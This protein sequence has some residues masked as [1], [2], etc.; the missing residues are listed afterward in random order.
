[1]TNLPHAIHDAKPFVL[2]LILLVGVPALVLMGVVACLGGGAIFSGPPTAAIDVTESGDG[3]DITVVDGGTSSHVYLLADDTAIAV[4]SGDA[5]TAATLTNLDEGTELLV[6]GTT[7]SAANVVSTHT[8]Q[9]DRG[10]TVESPTVVDPGG[11]V[12]RA[13][14]DAETVLEQQTMTHQI[15]QCGADAEETVNGWV[16]AAHDLFNE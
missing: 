9:S 11:S 3:V 16:E 2:I 6:V 12:T 14:T 1:M 10:D 7:G 8:L 15:T 13:D 4:M 5:G